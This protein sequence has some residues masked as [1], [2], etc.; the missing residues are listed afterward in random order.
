[1]ATETKIYQLRGVPLD[2]WAQF[3]RGAMVMHGQKPAARLRAL[4]ERDVA[5]FEA[6]HP[7]LAR[8]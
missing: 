1:V 5:E 2:V 7:D 3:E 4:I 8:T 6:K